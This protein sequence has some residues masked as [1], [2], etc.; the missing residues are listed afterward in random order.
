MQN[1]NAKSQPFSASSLKLWFYALSFS[2]LIFSLCGCSASLDVTDF[3]WPSGLPSEDDIT[4][5]YNQI[6]LKTSTSA[7]VLS[8]I[9][10]PE[11]ELLSQSKSVV[12]SM[13]QKKK[14]FK[15]WLKMAAFNEDDLTVRRKYVLIEDEKPK[16]LFVEPWAKLKFDCQMVLE[17][18]IL[19]EPYAN[20]N[21]KQIAI[22]EHAQ[23]NIR[24]DID[25]VYLD[26]KMI[27]VSGMLINQ[28]I[29]TVLVKLT[30]S[31]A[32]AT[33]LKEPKGLQFDH[34]SYDKGRI[35]MTLEEDIVSLRIWLGS[36]LKR[37]LSFEKP[38]RFEP[39]EPER[40]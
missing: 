40:E 26:N 1:H 3:L 39:N 5:V 7:D 19:N 9:N 36:A 6:E 27:Q 38:D 12:A 4:A 24:G 14:G 16:Q 8:I 22:L 37:K 11:E 13:G 28:A 15:T 29:E 2:L 23:K 21:A 18:E 34:I 10:I 17:E 31:P 20:D 35:R 25:L 32:A 30:T 33:R